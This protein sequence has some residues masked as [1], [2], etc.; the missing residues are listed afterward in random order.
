M[1]NQ[2]V[3]EN[4]WE[5]ERLHIQNKLLWECEQPVF[6]KVFKGRSGARV[7]DI[8]CNNGCKTMER[9]DRPEVSRVMGLEYNEALARWAHGR[10]GGE[11]FSF[12]PCDL[13][14]PSFA[15]ELSALMEQAGIEAFDVIYASFVLMHLRDPQTV[16]KTLR[17]F[18]APGGCLLIEEADDLACSLTPDRQGL[19]RQFLQMLALDPYA[20]NRR[21][22][23][24][25]VGWLERCGYRRIQQ[26]P[27]AIRATGGQLK[28]KEDIFEV[29]FSYFP[30]DIKLLQKVEQKNRVWFECECWLERNYDALRENAT[31]MKSEFVFALQFILCRECD[32]V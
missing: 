26:L 9:F 16:L 7:L 18:L 20:G 21:C 1:E 13:E 17:P 6:D 23:E 25:V 29:F 28:K 3:F 31:S 11:V 5:V 14:S 12:H 24:Q 15:R 22:G 30:Q 32:K 10:H 8:G 4:E 19:F 27:A 2:A